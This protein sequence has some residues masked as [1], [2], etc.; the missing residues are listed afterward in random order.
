MEVET[1]VTRS[2]AIFV[3]QINRLLKNKL[4]INTY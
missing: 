4:E 1:G 2:E 3:D